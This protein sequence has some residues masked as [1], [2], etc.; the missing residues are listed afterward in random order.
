MNHQQ[1]TVLKVS[2]LPNFSMGHS[3]L[4]FIASP[5]STGLSSMAL[6]RG[7]LLAGG[8]VPLHSL[9]DPEC[10]YVLAGAM[11]VYED[12]QG[13]S[14]WTLVQE[15]GFAV[16][17][18]SVKHAWRNQSSEPCVCLIVT[19]SDVFAFFRGAC[20]MLEAAERA[21][22]PAQE[23]NPKSEISRRGDPL[24]AS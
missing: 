10:F 3:Q 13:S 24:L 14:E 17:H 1:H 6:I 12:R 2:S 8:H 16:T 7:K 19:G 11:E 9:R 15:G 20:D 22:T 21:R 5:E 4:Q 23:L 18:G